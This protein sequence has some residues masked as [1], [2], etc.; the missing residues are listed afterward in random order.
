MLAP[1]AALAAFA[2]VVTRADLP[3]TPPLAVAM[4]LS[5]LLAVTLVSLV[6]RRLDRAYRVQA[7]REAAEDVRAADTGMFL[8]DGAP[9]AGLADDGHGALVVTGTARL[10]YRWNGM[11]VGT[12]ATLDPNS[13]VPWP[14]LTVDGRPR[15]FSWRTWAYRLP[16]GEHEVAVA[17]RSPAP[18]RP[19]VTRVPVRVRVAVGQVTRLELRV[20]ARTEVRANRGRQRVPTELA[21]F[22]A[23]VEP[24]VR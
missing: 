11:R 19:E 1:F 6:K 17:V 23:T 10:E 3:V 8:A 5:P 14:T 9:P 15:P 22:T 13:W 4:L 21:G 20:D 18:D 12:P 7:S 24:R 2:L 16:P